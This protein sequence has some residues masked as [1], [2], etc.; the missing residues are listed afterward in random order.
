MSS[1]GVPAEAERRLTSRAFSSALTVPDFAACL[2]MGLRPVGLVQGFCVMK[3][4]WY[5]AGS[6][7]MRG[8][9]GSRSGWGTTLSTY[10]CPHGYGYGVGQDHRSWG[11]NFEQPWLSSVWQDGYNAA[12]QRMVAEASEA[13]AHGVVGVVDTTSQLVDAG[14]REFHLLGTA[15]VAEG[16][17]P[18]PHVWSTYLA[19]QR[20]TKLVEAGFVPVSVVAAISSIRVWEVCETEILMRGGYDTWGVV[21]PGGAVP[22]VADAHMEARRRA[23]DQ[24]KRSLGGNVL[25]GVTV[26]AA[27]HELGEGDREVTCVIRGNSVRREREAEALATPVPTVRLS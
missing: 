4:S 5:G 2:D 18:P 16:V 3:W 25:H 9:Y 11:E 7:Y 17:P 13:G 19:G 26:E 24:I 20:L 23:R 10:Q 14:I 1:A 27:E 8:P 21:Q 22:Q 15:V 6:A 12:Y